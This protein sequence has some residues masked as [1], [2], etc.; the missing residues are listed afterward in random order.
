MV[1]VRFL[2]GPFF[3]PLGSMLTICMQADLHDSSQ[4]LFLLLFAFGLVL[5]WFKNCHWFLRHCSAITVNK[6]QGHV[7]P[8]SK[9]PSACVTCTQAAVSAAPETTNPDFNTTPPRQLLSLASQS[10]CSRPIR[11]SQSTCS[12]LSVSTKIG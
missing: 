12:P 8:L 5:T 4:H 6:V 1:Q 7:D 3:L 11:A 2:V 10:R 9:Q